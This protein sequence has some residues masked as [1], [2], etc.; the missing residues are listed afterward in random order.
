MDDLEWPVVTLNDPFRF[1][2]GGF[3]TPSIHADPCKN[4]FQRFF[5]YFSPPPQTDNTNVNIWPIGD[6][7]WAVHNLTLG[8]SGRYGRPSPGPW[9]PDHLNDPIKGVLIYRNLFNPW[10]RSDDFG[11][12]IKGSNKSVCHRK[13]VNSTSSQW[14]RRYCIQYGFDVWEGNIL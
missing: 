8:R 13:S 6:K 4:I 12:A 11:V 1:I 7:V 2:F 10:S 9:S 14:S 5:A 3:G